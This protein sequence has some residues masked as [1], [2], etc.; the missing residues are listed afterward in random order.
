MIAMGGD[1][2]FALKQLQPEWDGKK[3]AR[4]SVKQLED[5]TN[6]TLNQS[7]DRLVRK[8]RLSFPEAETLGPALLAYVLLAKELNRSEIL[9]TNVNLRDGLLSEMSAGAAWSKEF[10]HQIIRSAIDLGNRF[11]FD[12]QHAV[13]V[14]DL[15]AK[16]FQ[17]LKDEHQLPPR[18]EVLLY[19]A[20]LLH[21]VGLFVSNRSYHKHSM[22]LIR[23]SELFGLGKKDLLLAALVA[24]YH[25]RASPQP[26]HEGY[27][28][29]ERDERV[30]VA[31]MSAIL[32]IAIALDESRSQ[33][34]HEVVCSHED[35]RL[36]ISVPMVEDLSLEQLSLK[37]NGSLFEET[38]GMPVLLRMAK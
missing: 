28:T 12:E 34:I 35:S 1:V 10:S 30:A 15:C 27:A 3:L 8:Y 2:R 16:L 37:Q 26:T 25:R 5:F 29:L 38:Y 18:N 22:Y 32:R 11:A 36:V 6:K 4:L 14:A 19:V 17:Q 9:V 21:E 33:R 31:K 24:R 13:H 7:E 23:N 20:A